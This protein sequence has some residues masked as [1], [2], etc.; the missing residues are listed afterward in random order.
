VSGCSLVNYTKRGVRIRGGCRDVFVSGCVADAG[1][2]EWA[3]EAFPIGFQVM[4]PHGVPEGSAV[5][6]RDVTFVDCVAR[7]NYHDAGA[8]YW[9][10]DG[11]CA[12]GG[13]SGMA[14][15]RCRALD[16]TDG[17]WDDKS[18]R[19]LLVECVALRNKRNFR[20]WG[21]EG[22]TLVRCASAFATKRGGSGGA[23]GLWAKGRVRAERC[24]FHANPS[25]VALEGEKAR[26]ELD[27]CIVS[28]DAS[29]NRDTKLH[30]DGAGIILTDSIVWPDGGDASDPRYV[31]APDRD[32]DGSGRGLESQAFGETHGWR[33]ETGPA[34][35]A[36]REEFLE[37]LARFK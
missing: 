1:G 18:V 36:S 28:S 35:G 16:N 27:H 21:A 12:E 19:P 11:F 7:N 29:V 25:A 22:A 14:Y 9:N 2:R 5:R 4:G 32:W 31:N 3:V 15:Y 6:D 37:F 24:T 30:A 34:P 33:T 13:C 8:K 20:F 10:A 26:V 17:G 23:D